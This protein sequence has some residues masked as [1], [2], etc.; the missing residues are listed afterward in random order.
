M[1]SMK[2]SE[3]LNFIAQ[4][5]RTWAEI[6]K[7]SGISSGSMSNYLRGWIQKDIVKKLII[8]NKVHY[9]I[10]DLP[11]KTKKEV[12]KDLEMAIQYFKH[13]KK[14]G[15]FSKG[16]TDKEIL[17]L[18]K[19]PKFKNLG[20]P[21]PDMEDIN[22]LDLLRLLAFLS[23]STFSLTHYLYSGVD[24]KLIVKGNPDEQIKELED[25]IKELKKK[26]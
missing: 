20:S 9:A 6:R 13:L 18:M 17:E 12:I 2:K 10:W 14:S 23:K 1:F 5:P 11:D 26:S 15:L 7:F 22:K 21:F 24:V 16:I 25:K 19:D 8:D 4:K 3:V